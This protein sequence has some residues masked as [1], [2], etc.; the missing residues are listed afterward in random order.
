M[1]DN[2]LPFRRP[3][4]STALPNDPFGSFVFEP[5]EQSSSGYGNDDG[6]RAAVG[7]WLT[8]FVEA[9]D[10]GFDFTALRRRNAQLRR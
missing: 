5:S 10:A 1:T 9:G 7:P 2:I 4:T 6:E 8:E 3:T